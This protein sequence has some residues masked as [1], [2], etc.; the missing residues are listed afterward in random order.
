MS[1]PIDSLDPEDIGDDNYVRCGF[2][3]CYQ[4]CIETEM[5]LTN[6]D[7]EQIEQNT[8]DTREEFLLPLEQSEGFLQLRNIPSPLGMKCYFLSDE[9]K[10]TIY[11][12]R[13]AGCQLYPL[14]L[15]MDT[16]E[17]MIDYDCREQDWFR[18]QVYLP[19]Q[20]LNIKSLVNTLL[21]EKRDVKGGKEDLDKLMSDFDF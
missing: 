15:N 12:F 20:V 7:V 3:D 18:E 16:D 19:L 1:L 2:K 13:P 10:C 11:E 5:I 14:I 9:G 4:C 17:A 8:L 21:L 6:Q